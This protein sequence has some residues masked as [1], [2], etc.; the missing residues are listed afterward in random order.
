VRETIWGVDTRENLEK[1]VSNL[2][3]DRTVR[4]D[5]DGTAHFTSD[6]GLAFGL[7]VYQKKRISSAPPDPV[8]TLGSVGRLN[9]SRKWRTRAR[10]K[11]IAHIVF[12]VQDYVKSFRFLEERLGFRLSEYQVG[13]GIYLRCDGATDHH[14][15][16][17]LDYNQGG[18]PGYPAFHHANFGVEDIDELQVGANYMTRRGWVF[19]AL[20]VGRHRIASA[21]FCYIKSPTGGDIEYGADSD[22]VDD[23]YVPREW[24]PLFGLQSWMSV[25]PDFVKN[26]EIEWYVRDLKG[27][28]APHIRS[29]ADLPEGGRL[30]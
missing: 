21:L 23:R 19:G 6:C 10:L 7:R 8:N 25:A 1:L 29:K 20:G 17:F 4:R 16:M 27:G 22:S 30:A 13:F 9:A 28:I 14:N 3:T 5:Q 11:T 15:I 12:A 24:D 26:A 18:S 2:T